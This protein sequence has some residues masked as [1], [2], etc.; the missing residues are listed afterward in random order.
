MQTQTI[1]FKQFLLTAFDNGEYATDDVIAFL[2]PLFE[3]VLSF[4]NDGMVAPFEKQGTLFITDNRLD[5]DEHHAHQPKN[6]IGKVNAL[7]KEYDSK[8]FVV[9]NETK[10]ETEVGDGYQQHTNL[11]IHVDLQKPMTSPAYLLGYRCF[12][13]LQG[14]HD[15]LTDI[16]CLGL[17]LGSM[18]LSLDLYD[19]DDLQ[20]FVEYR[21]NPVYYN[22]RIHPTISSLITEMTELDRHKRCSDLYDSINRLHHYRDYDPEK[23]TDL[24]NVAGWVNKQISTRSQ[25]ILSKLRSRL[26]DTSKRNRL[27]YYKANNR[28]VNL[29][30]SSVPLVLHYQSVNPKMLFT[31]NDDISSKVKGMKEIP[32]NKYLRFE[33]HQYISSQLDRIKTEAQRDVNEYGFSQLKLVVAFLNW[34]NLKEDRNERI[35]SPLLLIPVEIKK[36]KGLK[37]DQFTMQVLDNAAEVNPVLSNY[38]RELYGIKLPDFIDFDEMGLPQ[39][40][41][42]LKQQIDSVNQG[43]QLNYIDKPRIKLIHTVAKQT[44]NN[45]RKRLRKTGRQLGSYKNI[46]YSYK[47]EHYKPLGLEIFRQRVEQHP[48]VLEFLVNEDIKHTINNLTG[49][50]TKTR[51]LYELQDSES[52][53]Y[54]WDVDTCNMVVGN[55]NYKKMS[56]VRDYNYVVDEK[57][58]HQVF[59]KLFSDK[60]KAIDTTNYALNNP[61]E[62]YHVV[63]ADPTQTKAIL[64]SRSQE[65]YIIQGPPGTGKSQTITNLIADFI[66]QGKNILFV[67]EKR[68]ALDVVYQRLKQQHLDELCCYIHDSQGDKRKFIENLKGTYEDFIKNKLNIATITVQRNNSLQKLQEQLQYLEQFH[69]TNNNVHDKAGI[70]IRELIEKLIALKPYS[71]NLSAQQQELLPH[72]ESWTSFGDILKQLSIALEETGAEAAFAEHPLSKVNDAVFLQQQPINLLQSTLQTANRLLSDIDAAIAQHNIPNEHAAKLNSIKEMVQDAVLLQPLAATNNLQLVDIANKECIAFEKEIKQYRTAIKKQE[73]SKAKNANWKNKF[74]EQDTINAFAVAAKNEK[75]FFSFLNSSW[76]RLKKQLLESYDFAQHQVKPSYSSILQQL[77]TEYEDARQVSTQRQSFSSNYGIDNIE[78]TYL[79]I[80]KLRSKQGDKEVDYLLSHPNAN[81]LVMNLSKLHHAMHLLEVQLQQ[82]M[83]SFMDKNLQELKDDMDSIS[84]NLDSL[85]ELLPSLQQFAQLPEQLK[86]A[87]RNIPLTPKQA[88]AS[89]AFKTWQYLLQSAK[90]FSATDASGIENAVNI[91]Q[92]EYKKLLQLNAQFIR[93]GI[94]KKF[95]QHIELSMMSPSQLNAEQKEFK[96]KYNEG[97]KILEH[98]FGKSMRFKSIRELSA[99]ES[100][101]VLKDIKPVW[102][103]SP[104]S[105]SDSLPVDVNYFDVVIFDEASQITLEEG[106]PALY[107]AKQSIIVGDEMQ[108]PPTNFFTA[109]AEDPDDLETFGDEE[110]E[111]LSADADSLLTQGARKLSSVMLGWHYRSRYETLISYSNHAFY[112]KGL[113]TIPDKTIHHNTKNEIIVEKAEDASQY[114][115]D[116]LNRSIS[117]HH[118]PN[119]VYEQRSNYDEAYYIAHLVRELLTQKTGNSIGIVAFSQEQQHQIE[120]ALTALAASDKAFEE[121]L[122]AEYNRTEDDQFVGLIVK[123]LE[124]IQGDERDIIIMSVCYGFDER[125]KMLMNFGPINKKGGEKRLNVIF[126]RAKKHMAIISSIKHHNITNE[127]NEGANYFKRF[128]HYAE[129]VST[130]NMQTARVILDGLVNNRQE[131]KQSANNNYI[132]LQIQKELEAKG[133]ETHLNI[134]QSTFKCSLAVKQGKEDEAYTLGVVIDDEQHY[135]NENWLEQ[136]FQ[137]PAIL[138]SFGWRVMAL[139]AKDWLQQPQKIIEFIIKRLLQDPV[140]EKEE[141]LS[142]LMEQNENQSTDTTNHTISSSLL[143]QEPELAFIKL[144]STENGSNKFWEAAVDGNKLVVRFGK[145]G[146]K[147]QSQIKTFADYESTEKERQKLITAKLAKGYNKV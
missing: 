147:G 4:H 54:S 75:S 26:F 64:Q 24:S 72:Y 51:K 120:D 112:S 45:Y 113:L 7:F 97:R 11:N 19:E 121:I 142:V 52:N 25:F 71:A 53:P 59:E 124:N 3:E 61:T 40:Y 136:Y 114:V 111:I 106:I 17:I 22:N 49:D 73:E 99:K 67:C 95:A 37:E 43:I 81:Q 96:K 34:H 68:A 66:A 39:F 103:M 110:D 85:Q 60:P 132:L 13:E 130:G 135:Q 141:E 18:A 92:K 84:M 93:A 38:L 27:L 108:M 77:Q 35:Q 137:R 29:T 6:N 109:K 104:L 42:L 62:W 79:G 10:V 2:L 21:T 83:A 117:Y 9:T 56:L 129:M 74:S 116:V 118:L 12:E 126:S 30:V 5:I 107:R 36:R 123:N 98:E 119:S 20:T 145:T 33:D 87:I 8:G 63:M 58:E 125:K 65:S 134:G 138:Q 140:E 94:R 28:F 80:E 78:T 46:E 133:Y 146:T 23:Q 90:T 115:D 69:H 100:G 15:A 31:W 41:D 102:L 88:E 105:V 55:F 48:S 16:F 122:E 101:L 127:Y 89:I 57:V 82:G 86:H 143:Q 47:P 131:E 76:R 70:R 139:F 144:V 32:L 50:D 14:H 128:L 1:D 44:V 91:I